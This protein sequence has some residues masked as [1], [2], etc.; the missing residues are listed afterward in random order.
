M[1]RSTENRATR[2]HGR[3]QQRLESA[4]GIN[5]LLCSQESVVIFLL[6]FILS[7]FLFMRLLLFVI[8][9][10]FKLF[11]YGFM[12]FLISLGFG[13]NSINEE[14]RQLHIPAV[15]CKHILYFFL[16]LFGTV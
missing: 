14:T 7:L 1:S 16:L 4:Y 2:D 8:L 12:F 6:S 5:F 9:H 11:L 13:S 15:R 3:R 10:P